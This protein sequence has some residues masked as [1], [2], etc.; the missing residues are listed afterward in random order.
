MIELLV[1]VAIIGILASVVLASLNTARL[2][3][4]DVAVKADM[5]NLRAQAEIWYEGHS[6]KYNIGSATTTCDTGVF[7][8]TNITAAIAQIT[9]QAVAPDCYTSADGQ[10]WAMDVTLLKGAQTSWCVDNSGWA[11]EGVAGATGVCAP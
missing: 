9:L 4:A 7:V 10:K 8:D 1:V 6:N 5:A 3:G 11:K 2:K